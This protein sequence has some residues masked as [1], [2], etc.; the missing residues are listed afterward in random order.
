MPRVRQLN[1][2]IKNGVG[3]GDGFILFC[4]VTNEDN[5]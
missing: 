1:V 3:W 5:G 4:A 2:K